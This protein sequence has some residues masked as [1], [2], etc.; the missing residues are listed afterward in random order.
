VPALVALTPTDICNIA[1]SMIG[2]ARI[3][4]TSDDNDTARLCSYLF[5]FHRQ[6]LIRSYPWNFARV[7]ITLDVDSTKPAFGFKYR[8]ELPGSAMGIYAVRNKGLPWSLEQWR[9][10]IDIPEKLDVIYGVDEQVVTN[11]DPL[12]SELLAAKIAYTA[13]TRLVQSATL[14]DEMKREYQDIKT[15]ALTANAREAASY[16]SPQGEWADVFDGSP[17]IYGRGANIHEGFNW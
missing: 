8:Y 5:N 3:S 7:R 17:N 4:S 9:I 2:H 15:A 6:T 10:L 13:A 1:L 11:F 14:R 12:F 16:L